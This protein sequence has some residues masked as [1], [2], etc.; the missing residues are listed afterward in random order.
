MRSCL[1]LAVLTATPLIAQGV[2]PPFPISQTNPLPSLSAPNVP[3]S[4]VQQVNMIH[5]PSDPPNV[6]LCSATSV[7][8]P[9]AFGGVGGSDLVTGSYDVIADTFTPNS[10]A[11]A[12]NTAGTE[13]GMMIDHSGLFAV[14]DR[15]PGPPHLASRAATGQPWQHVAAVGP[16]PTQAYYDPSLAN[17]HGQ[18]HLLHV[19]GTGIAMTPID[20]VTGA[21]IGPSVVIAL[22]ARPGSTAN[23]PTPVVDPNGELIGISHHDVLGSDNDHY[24]SLDLD[25]NTPA[26]LM[27]DTPTWINNGGFIGGRFFDAEF[28][29]SPYHV[30]SMDTYWFTGGR[31]PVGGTMYVTFNSPPTSGPEV[32]LSLFGA[33]NAFLPVGQPLPPLNG[34]LGLNVAGVITSPL[35]AHNNLNGQAQLSFVI[36]NVPALSGTRLPAQSV[37]IA[38]IANQAY[39]GNTAMLTVD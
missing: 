22:A 32:Y 29:P 6:Y 33:G 16:I 5:L 9:A 25:P 28:T 7:G 3:G 21:L 18:P 8:L 2:V 11:A 20:L 19:L 17:Y 36:P 38:V 27:N 30:F 15:L 12:L 1:A 4:S 34:L 37:T 35:L 10:E 31:A 13:F 14:F 26:V 39:F 24:M 23:S